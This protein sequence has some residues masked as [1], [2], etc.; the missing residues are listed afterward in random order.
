MLTN[1][2]KEEEYVKDLKHD[3][4]SDKQYVIL[5]NNIIEMFDRFLKNV[6]NEELELNQI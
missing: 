4:Y 5:V 1:V 6:E 2:P 3:M